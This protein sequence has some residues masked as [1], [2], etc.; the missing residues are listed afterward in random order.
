MSG[1]DHSVNRRIDGHGGGA[2]LRKEIL[3][4]GGATGFRKKHPEG[5]AVEELR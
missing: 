5:L 2:V 4:Y 1:L 3:Y